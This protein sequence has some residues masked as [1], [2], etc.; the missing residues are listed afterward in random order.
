[1]LWEC[2][3]NL[4]NDT[5][6]A[7]VRA[8]AGP[9]EALP[10]RRLQDD[11]DRP[12]VRDG[13][14]R[15]ARGDARRRT[16]ATTTCACTASRSAAP[17]VGAVAPDRCRDDNAGVVESFKTVRADGRH[18]ARRRRVLP[19][20]VRSLLRHRH[21][22]TR[23]R[24]S[25]TARS[26]AGRAPASRSTC[27]RTSRRAA[28]ACAA[29]SARRSRRGARTS[30]RRAPASARRSSS[31]PDWQFEGVVFGVLGARTAGHLPGRARS[32][33]TGCTT[34]ARA[35]AP[36]HRYTTSTATRDADARAGLDSRG[37]RRA[38]RDHVRAGLSV[39]RPA[40]TAAR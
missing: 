31:N 6:A 35:R 13:A 39:P 29:S 3:S 5:G 34:T 22:R 14:R 32:R 4:L 33:S 20:G 27:I 18:A 21:R 1:M 11:A 9:D 38:R 8:G 25:T 30:T 24:S 2:Y 12:D 36:N 28:P 15:A 7:H 19:R 23:S 17:G 10:R 37:L 40:A 16:R 26:S